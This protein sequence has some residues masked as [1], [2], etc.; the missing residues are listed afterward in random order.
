[1]LPRLVDIGGPWRVLPP[2]IHDATLDETKRRFGGNVRRATLFEGFERAYRLLTAA[3]CTT[4][5]LDGSYVTGKPIP[6]DF[7]AC[8]DPTGVDLSA[9]D[10]I[11]LDLADGRRRQKLAFGGEFFPSRPGPDGIPPFVQF[12][13]VDRDTGHAKGLVR[14]VV[15]TQRGGEPR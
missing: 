8:W 6:G 4:V 10:P 12:F 2:G 15:G 11:L 13:G 7:D 9:L 1:V 3:G 14:I 5:Y